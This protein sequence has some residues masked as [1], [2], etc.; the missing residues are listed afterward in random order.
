MKNIYALL[1]GLIFGL[2]LIVSGMANPEKVI[3][4]LNIFG[5]WD[6]SLAF[7]MGG[8]IFVGVFS[9]KYIVKREKTLLGG[10]LHLS[11]EKSINKRLIF[12]SLIF[13]LGWGVAGFC[14]G[15]ALVSLG[16]GSLKGALFVIA[17]LAGMLVFKLFQKNN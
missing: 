5:R 11:N 12:G 4:F 6:P 1:A 9:F 8:A 10:S 16:M 7:V 15:P 3:G 13:G 17:M 2:G 14:P